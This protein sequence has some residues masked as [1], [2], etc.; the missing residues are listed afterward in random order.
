MNCKF[1]FKPIQDRTKDR[2]EVTGNEKY[3]NNSVLKSS[4]GLYQAAN[5][6]I[7]DSDNEQTDINELIELSLADGSY[8][9]FDIYR[10]IKTGTSTLVKTLRN[11]WELFSI[12]DIYGKELVVYP[13]SRERYKMECLN[14]KSVNLTE[15]DS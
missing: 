6:T 13:N 10:K 11:L 8:K 1:Q 5:L 3:C 14:V 9:M 7:F 4:G 12:N 15:K 2:F